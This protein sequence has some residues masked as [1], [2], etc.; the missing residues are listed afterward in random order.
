M[1]EACKPYH[2][3]LT[4]LQVIDKL[5]DQVLYRQLKE[6]ANDIFT[7]SKNDDLQRQ[8][9]EVQEKVNSLDK[10]FNVLAKLNLPP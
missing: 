2:S 9:Q 6:R 7:A 1:C 10:A 4:C 3:D 8:R 5:E